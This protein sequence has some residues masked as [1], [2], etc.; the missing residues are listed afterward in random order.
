MANKV[1]VKPLTEH[2][3]HLLLMDDLK[4]ASHDAVSV[5][6]TSVWNQVSDARKEAIIDTLFNLGLPR[7]KTFEQFIGAVKRGDWDAAANELLLSNAAHTN[8]DRY[9]RN[10]RVMRTNNRKYFRL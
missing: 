3:V 9:F 6:G 2:D 10:S 5:F 7:F 8:P 4:S 1:F